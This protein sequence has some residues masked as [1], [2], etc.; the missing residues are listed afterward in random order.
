MSRWR[1]PDVVF[2]GPAAASVP[3]LL[4]FGRGLTFFSVEWALIADRSL[5]DRPWFI[6]IGRGGIGAHRDPFSLAALA[7]I[8]EGRQIFVERA[9]MTRALVP[10]GSRVLA[11]ALL[12]R[13][14]A[15]LATAVIALAIVRAAQHRL[16]PWSWLP[17]RFRPLGEI[18]ES[19]A[20]AVQGRT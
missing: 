5:T 6:L 9:E 2:A 10:V 3:V 1:A 19:A 15:P 8:P 14:P 7:H 12:A 16:D 4:W 17:E 20:S 18:R 11:L 13:V